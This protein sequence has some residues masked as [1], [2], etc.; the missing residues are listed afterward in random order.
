MT[1]LTLTPNRLAYHLKCESP[2]EGEQLV[3]NFFNSLFDIKKLVLVKNSIKDKHLIKEVVLILNSLNNV[4]MLN[5]GQLHISDVRVTC[6]QISVDEAESLIRLNKTKLY[7]GNIPCGVDNIKLWKHF[8]RFGSLDYTYIIKKPD[9]KA[10]GFGFI[11]YEEREGFERAIRAK[12]YIEG[13]RLICKIFL[14]KSQ[15]TRHQGKSEAEDETVPEENDLPESGFEL[16]LEEGKGGS[17]STLHSDRNIQTPEEVEA[18]LENCP[19]DSQSQR[20]TGL[21]LKSCP[22]FEALEQDLEGGWRGR[23]EILEEFPSSSNSAFQAY[24]PNWNLYYTKHDSN[25]KPHSAQDWTRDAS[26]QC[27]SKSYRPRYTEQQASQ[28]SYYG[29]EYQPCGIQSNYNQF[30][31]DGPFYNSS[32]ISQEGRSYGWQSMKRA[33][34]QYYTSKRV[35]QRGKEKFLSFNTFNQS[36]SKEFKNT[37]TT[38]TLKTQLSPKA[39]AW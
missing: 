18:E 20:R 24:D 10:K 3:T 13:Q 19:Q 29:P 12:H 21:K 25:R 23:C 32:T 14:N 26:F 7:V 39:K 17:Q 35:E 8:A 16:R 4:D 27:N 37:S 28:P 15:L 38:A 5:Q 31:Y 9:R 11:I 30:N 22:Y 2:I 1:T 6:S 36:P 33:S 34:G